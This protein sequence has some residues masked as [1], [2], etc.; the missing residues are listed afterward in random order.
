MRRGLST[1]GAILALAL[2]ASP[3]ASAR[4]AAAINM[5]PA[6]APVLALLL[7]T[8]RGT[9]QPVL[10]VDPRDRAS[11]D[12]FRAEWP[13]PVRCFRLPDTG[14]AVVQMMRE[15]AG[16]PCTV[17]T[18]MAQFARTLWPEARVA[19][20][21][22]AAPGDRQE[23]RSYRWL[24]RAAAFAGATGSA[25]LPLPPDPAASARALDGWN[26]LYV[27]P[28]AAAWRAAA[29][30]SIPN[31]ID[32]DKADTLL[33][34]F[35]KK[36]GMNRDVVVVANAGDR[37]GLFSPAG[38]SLLAPL[39]AAAH[40]A[41]L[42]LVRSAE[43]AAAEGQ[44]LE[45]LA[46][47]A[48]SPS[49]VMLVGDEI[50]LR[51]HRVEDPVAAAG[52]PEALGGGGKVRVELFSEI[53]HERPQDL[54]VGRI[55]A[56]GVGQG[57][58]TLARQLHRQPRTR[59]RPAV[60]FSNAD[61]IFPLGETISRTT[62]AEFRNVGVPVRAYYGDEVTTELVSRSLTET[63]LLV[64]EGHTRD[65]TLG[66][67]GGVAAIAAPEVVVLQGCHTFDRSDPFILMEKGTVALLGSSTA[68]YSAPGS[69]LAR[70]FFD[71]LLYER[72]D[73]GTAARN[74][75]N[76]AL[77]LAQLQ[78]MRGHGDWRKTYRAALAFSL[79]GDPTLRLHIKPA[80]PKIAPVQWTA[81]DGGLTLTIPGRQ[82]GT[83]S[84]AGY[85]ARPSSRAMLGGLLL[86]EKD[87][88]RR[89]LK[90]LYF[91]VQEA[92]AAQ[93]LTACAPARGWDVVSLYAPRTETLTV[94]ARPD[95]KML[96]QAP[97]RRPFVFPLAAEARACPKPAEEGA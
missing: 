13:G 7:S 64:W 79:W 95:W 40:R 24:L 90:D 57:S 6:D 72:A 42:V 11:T 89:P 46:Y 53:Q 86:R 97:S 82:L 69:A 10:L 29:R 96:G 80:R 37:D 51:S 48:L 60:L 67:R 38:L 23:D 63:D 32:I 87:S 84:V 75:R 77:A 12:G 88:R 78:R 91:T 3:P 73:L 18:D 68:I 93:P 76:F 74:A 36:D 66:E 81:G 26:V 43:P 49:Y 52:G 47:H 20:A 2:V 44:V 1:A 14:K 33:T 8:A 25:L 27:L 92:G 5:V 83:V 85:R 19:V 54:I 35:L 62:A 94:L 28:T 55:A 70:A 41:P 71:A 17:V 30:Q 34:E 61:R 45:T 22:V 59:Q 21:T 39:A 4:N 56:E 16:E 65:L 58:A 31:V 50:A 9:S 15:A